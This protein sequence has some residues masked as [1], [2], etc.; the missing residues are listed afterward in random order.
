MNNTIVNK[1]LND[2]INSLQKI[3]KEIVT[4]KSFET[5]C[6]KCLKVIKKNKKIPT[7]FFFQK[8]LILKL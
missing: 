5:L 4:L 2:E 7:K 1:I 8:I 3:L 6:I